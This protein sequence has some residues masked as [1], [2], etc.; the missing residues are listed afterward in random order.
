MSETCFAKKF[1]T[2]QK[3]Y[4]GLMPEEAKVGDVICVIYGC[5]IPGVLRSC[6][7]GCFRLIGHGKVHSFNFDDAVVESTFTRQ[8]GMRNSRKEFTFA[9]RNRAGRNVYTLLKETRK[10]TLL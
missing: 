8:R 9:T 1:A 2:T 7:G 3:R 5:E 10:F 6:E 4:M